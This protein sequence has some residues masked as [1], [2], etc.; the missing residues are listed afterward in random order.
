MQ[1]AFDSAPTPLD[2]TRPRLHKEQIAAPSAERAPYRPA[3]Q[4]THAL[5]DIA[6]GALVV[7]PIAHVPLQLLAPRALENRP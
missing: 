3:K 5:V 7:A 6:P 4:S 2:D 1:V